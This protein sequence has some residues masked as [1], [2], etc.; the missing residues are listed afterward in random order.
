MRFPICGRDPFTPE[1]TLGYVT[2]ALAA[3]STKRRKKM[4]S[5]VAYKTIGTFL[6]QNKRHEDACGWA[7]EMRS[8]GFAAV[9]Q[10][11]TLCFTHWTCKFDLSSEFIRLGMVIPP[12]PPHNTPIRPSH[13][14]AVMIVGGGGGTEPCHSAPHLRPGPPLVRSSAPSA[15]TGE[16]VPGPQISTR[17]Q[18]PP[19][20]S[21]L[22]HASQ[23]P[24]GQPPGRP[25]A[26]GN[27]GR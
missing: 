6:S 23:G 19:G 2:C 11:P 25:E 4:G 15:S 1:R 8:S 13:I 20:H 24:T 27:E 17:Q 16:A 5:S 18:Q 9:R 3:N 26:P 10:W 22:P 12:P 21:T 7:T 14:R